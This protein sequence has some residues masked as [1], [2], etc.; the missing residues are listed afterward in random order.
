MEKPIDRREFLC[1]TATAI[2]AIAFATTIS[3]PVRKPRS[4]FFS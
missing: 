3:L 1:A 2:G 4:P